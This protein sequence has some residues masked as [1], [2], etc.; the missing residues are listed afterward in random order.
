[1]KLWAVVPAAGVGRRMG[2]DIPKQYLPLQGSRVL[3]QSLSRLLAHAAIKRIYLALSPDDPWWPESPLAGSPRIRVVM[4]G[5]ERCH[6]VQNALVAL[7]READAD[8][9]VLVHDAARPCLRHQDLELLIRRAQEHPV[10]GLLGQRVRDSM[11]ETNAASE[12]IASPDRAQL[13]H[14][15]TPQMFRLGALSQALEAAIK[16]G[17]PVTDEASAIEFMGQ[18]PLLVEGHDDNI[19]ITRPGDLALATFYLERQSCA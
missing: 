9:W 8:D 7:A 5:A 17:H 3:E 15:F 10:G 4:G 19:K 12:V 13:W 14:A 18:R 16:A 1:M 11:K 6:S 2:S